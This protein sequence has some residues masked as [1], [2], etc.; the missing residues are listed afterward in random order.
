M[1]KAVLVAG[2]AGYIGSHVCKALAAAGY[3][4]VV[5]DDFSAGHRDFVKFGPLV[6]ACVSDVEAVKHVVSN[7]GIEAVI[8]LAGSIEVSESVKDPLKYYDNNVAK[9]IAFLRALNRAGVKAFV[10]SSTAAVYGEPTVIPIPE[11]HVTSPTNPYGWSK[12]MFERL[13]QSNEPVSGMRFMALRY[14]NAAGASLDGD[15]GE[16]HDPETHLIPRACL[17]NL[18]TIPPLEI[19]GNDYQTPDGTAVRDYVHVMDLAQAHVL[20]VTAL[21]GGASSAT[22]NLGNGVGT[23]IG[24]IVAAFAQMG[25]PVPHSFKGRRAGDPSRLV[26]DSS[27]VRA[28][29]GWKPQYADIATI[30]GSAYRWHQQS[31]SKS[32]AG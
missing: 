1:T 21:L 9:K 30:I 28:G 3:V 20:A 12:L 31:H 25:H 4:P 27:A 10:F 24:E 2:G 17:A 15:L 22:Y 11:T 32:N 26:A 23:S 5:L 13:L 18:G 19:F 6:E 29:L 14:F 16:S 8:D 7:Y